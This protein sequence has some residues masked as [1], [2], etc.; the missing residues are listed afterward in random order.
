MRE[1]RALTLALLIVVAALGVG[2]RAQDQQQPVVVT[3]G[4]ASVQRTPDVAFVS[5]AAEAHART[6][7]EAQQQN[8]ATMTAV[9]KRLTELGIPADAR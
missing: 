7:R 5:L 4:T 8:A 2:A 3:N 6:P 9:A 1:R